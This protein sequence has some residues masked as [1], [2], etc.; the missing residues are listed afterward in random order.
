ME[1]ERATWLEEYA[2]GERVSEIARRHQV[3][4]KTVYKWVERYES[5]ASLEDLS[6]VPHHHP[7]RV[8]EVWRERV[9]AVRHSIRAGERASWPGS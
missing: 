2:A 8:E 4:R 1:W 5:G 7:N 9:R 3:S 6:R